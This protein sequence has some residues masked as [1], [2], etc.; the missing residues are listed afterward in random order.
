MDATPR[1][2]VGGLDAFSDELNDESPRG[3]AIV[4]AALLDERLRVLLDQVMVADAK[5]RK[6]LLGDDKDPYGP[7]SSFSARI[8]AAYC[9]GLISKGEFEDL[10]RIHF[11]RNRFAHAQYGFSFDDPKVAKACGDMN[12]PREITRPVDSAAQRNNRKL[13]EVVVALLVS[14]LESRTARIEGSRPSTPA[15]QAFTARLRVDGEWRL[16]QG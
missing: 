11:I 14:S 12:I 6:S 1:V 5:A 9:F 7:L 3:A 16:Q 4:G 10:T 13:F 2:I 15:D 8:R